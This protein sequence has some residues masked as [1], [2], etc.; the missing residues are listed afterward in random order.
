MSAAPGRLGSA[1]SPFAQP[2]CSAEQCDG[3]QTIDRSGRAAGSFGGGSE[4]TAHE[5]QQRV[6]P[7][8]IT[9]VTVRPCA[10]RL[11]FGSA[12]PMWYAF[13]VPSH[14]FDTVD[15]S[16]AQTN[17]RRSVDS[18]RSRLCAAKDATERYLN[19]SPRKRG[20]RFKVKPRAGDRRCAAEG[21]A[22]A[23]RCEKIVRIQVWYSSTAYGQENRGEG[24]TILHREACEPTQRRVRT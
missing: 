12:R 18:R 11:R 13:T 3:E 20:A 2:L 15:S 14:Y 17:A 5:W 8:D 22:L 1:A 16:A 10:L 9:A 19:P 7:G 23:G 21:A 24:D 6:T 4:R